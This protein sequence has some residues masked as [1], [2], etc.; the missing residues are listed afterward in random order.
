MKRLI[1]VLAMV[2]ALMAFTA[3]TALAFP[4]GPPTE[5]PFPPCHSPAF[6][7]NAPQVLLGE[8][9]FDC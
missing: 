7:A 1:L 2:M 5:A 4:P 6:L 8:L 9:G 3:A